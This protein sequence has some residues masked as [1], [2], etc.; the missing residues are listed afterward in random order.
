MQES[1]QKI[2]GDILANLSA[3][4]QLRILPNLEDDDALHSGSM[5]Q[6]ILSHLSAQFL[7]G[8]RICGPTSAAYRDIV[9]PLD[10]PVL[11]NSNLVEGDELSARQEAL[12]NG[13]EAGE[14]S[15]SAV[16]VQDAVR[17]DGDMLQ[18]QA[19]ISSST[20]GLAIRQLNDCEVVVDTELAAQ[21]LNSALGPGH[22]VE[23]VQ[24]ASGGFSKDTLFFDARYP[25]G[26]E[27]RLVVRR[28][29]PYGPGETR[30]VDE[31]S[32]LRGLEKTG[33][34]VAPALALDRTGILG[35][36]SMISAC[37][38]GRSGTED[39][40]GD[41]R[42]SQ[43]ITESLA[44]SLAR[45]HQISPSSV[46][47]SPSGSD[48]KA[49]VRDYVL[50][51]QDRWRRNRVFPSPTLAAAYEWLLDNIPSEIGRISIV[52][53]DVGFHNTLVENGKLNA[54]LDWEFAHL[55]DASE[56]LS[57]CRPFIEDIGMWD[58]FMEAYTAAGG[59]EYREENAHYFRVWR[60]VRNSTTCA[61][62][63]RGFVDA[64]Y[65][66]LKATAQGLCFYRMFLEEVAVALQSQTTPNN[67]Q[68]DQ[69]THAGNPVSND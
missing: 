58:A 15:I 57:Y 56:D 51:W 22:D 66:A 4:L 41:A 65:P 30:V 33:F 68:S 39:W 52:H 50:E 32:L 47:L 14:L 5:M 3:E 16:V 42:A 19:E 35:Q 40:S 48:P 49:T 55:G 67:T 11:T 25:E 69:P 28:D 1:E 13:I 44:Q 38:A 36:P 17:A 31:F 43:S 23:R 9:G 61:T 53:G 34:P 46:G 59:I 12:Q 29:L 26:R 21:L 7:H 60:A 20:A 37:I 62:A 63:F 18:R 10:Q 27:S 64:H 2:I 8:D 54:I 6:Q 24:R 45:L